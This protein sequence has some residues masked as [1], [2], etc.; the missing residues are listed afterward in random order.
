MFLCP[1]SL[2]FLDLS[3]FII[4]VYSTQSLILFYSKCEKRIRLMLIAFNIGNYIR[5]DTRVRQLKRTELA[6]RVGSAQ[7]LRLFSRSLNSCRRSY[8]RRSLSNVHRTFFTRT[9]S[10]SSRGPRESFANAVRGKKKTTHGVNKYINPL[11]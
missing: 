5:V 8:N 4:Y 2:L 11:F 1:C 7:C 9:R 3:F 10:R 6:W